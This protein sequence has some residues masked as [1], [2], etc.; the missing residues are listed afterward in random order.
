M[1]VFAQK[2]HAVED[3]AKAGYEEWCAKKKKE[4]LVDEKLK[5]EDQKRQVRVST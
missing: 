5:F 3:K 2:K 4:R 1:L